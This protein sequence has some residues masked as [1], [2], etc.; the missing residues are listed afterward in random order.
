MSA[1]SF[2]RVIHGDCLA[3]LPS[4]PSASVDAAITDP[5]YGVRYRDRTGRRVANDDDLHRILGAFAEIARVLKPD[6]FCI[7]FYGWNRI[8]AFFHA[9]GEAGLHPVGHLV[10]TKGYASS[11]RFLEARHEQAYLLAKG[12]PLRPAVPPP[13]VQPWEYT[14]NVAHPTEKAVGILR[15]LVAAF[16]P[17]GGVVLDP[18]AG[19]G[20]TLVAAALAGRQYL[21]IELEEAYCRLAE[22]RLDG[23]ARFRRRAA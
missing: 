21:G 7:S 1:L 13:D 16:T 2:S 15:P 14:G 10:W 23:V 4:L 22:R 8:D 12:N 19:S 5:P 11:A 3:V 6:T 17:P 9:W 20:S 18:F